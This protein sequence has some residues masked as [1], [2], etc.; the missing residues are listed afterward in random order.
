MQQK[1][2]DY[3]HQHQIDHQFCDLT[4]NHCNLNLPENMVENKPLDI[5]NIKEKQDHDADLQQSATRYPEWYGCK[6]INSIANVLCYTKPNDNPS[7]WKLL[8]QVS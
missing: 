2:N 5:E 6:N 1:N 3:H 7:N 8:Y 4:D